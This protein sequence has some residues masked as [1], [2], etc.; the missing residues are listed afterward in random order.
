[1]RMSHDA[2]DW[3]SGAQALVNSK[4]ARNIAI[5]GRGTFDGAAQW[6]YEPVNGWTPKSP[7]SR[8]SRAGPV[9]R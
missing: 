6:A 9:S 2:A 8:R 1:M 3:P 5:T 7:R 4:G